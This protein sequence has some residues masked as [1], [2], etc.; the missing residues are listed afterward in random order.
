MREDNLAVVTLRATPDSIGD[1]EYY[2]GMGDVQ[3]EPTHPGA[4]PRHVFA[5]LF[6]L[7]SASGPGA[8]QP[9]GSFVCSAHEREGVRELVRAASLA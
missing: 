4:K 8:E 7:T 1:G 2:T 9:A 6:E 5:Q 3:R